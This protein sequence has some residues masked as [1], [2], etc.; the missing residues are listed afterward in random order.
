MLTEDCSAIFSHPSL[1]SS[2]AIV[3]VGGCPAAV[4]RL[5]TAVVGNEAASFPWLSWIAFV[6]SFN[7]GCSYSI[8]AVWSFLIVSSS[9]I[10][11]VEPDTEMPVIAL[12]TPS[13]AAMNF[14]ALAVADD[15]I[16]SY[17]IIIFEPSVLVA[18]D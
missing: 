5:V 3:I 18:T 1:P 2:N 16:S 10:S 15:R 13:T 12:S 8:V 6:S 11:I 17:S 9:S 4:E 7:D 14:D